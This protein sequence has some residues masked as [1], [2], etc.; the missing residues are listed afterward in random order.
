M[1]PK[2]SAKIRIVS[3]GQVPVMGS[4]GAAGYDVFARE[5]IKVNANYY[6]VKL[7]I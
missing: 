2:K 4:E 7:G 3:G 6:K 5:I 1:K